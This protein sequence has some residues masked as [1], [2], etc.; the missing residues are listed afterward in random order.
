MRAMIL[1]RI[2]PAELFSIVQHNR[3]ESIHPRK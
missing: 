1:M 3:K 2:R